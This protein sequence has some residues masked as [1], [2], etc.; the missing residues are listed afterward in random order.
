MNTF[1]KFE[2]VPTYKNIKILYLY[3]QHKLYPKY[4]K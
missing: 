2:N 1:F 4:E 3:P